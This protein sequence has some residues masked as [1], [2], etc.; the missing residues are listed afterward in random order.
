MRPTWFLGTIV[1][2]VTVGQIMSVE[3]DSQFNL[4]GFVIV[5]I[6]ALMSALRWTLAQRVMHRDPNAPGDHAT[7]IKSSHL[8]DHP[9][10]F[11]YLLMP[12]MCVTVF[13]FSCV[14]EKWLMF[15]KVQIKL[16]KLY[17]PQYK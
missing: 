7:G 3:G 9:V 11:V 6:A 16:K 14:K 1:A 8:V 2:M 10:V 17:L 4:T 15:K 13:I 12:V 5:I